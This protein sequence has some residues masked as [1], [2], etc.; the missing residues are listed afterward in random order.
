MIREFRLKNAIGNEWDLNDR[1]SFLQ[2]P[3]GLG[4]EYDVEYQQIGNI[5]IK[6]TDNMKQKEASGQIVFKTYNRYHYFCLFIQHKPIVLQYTTQAGT[7][8]MDVSIDRLDKS[9]LDTG[10]LYCDVRI[11]GLSTFYKVIRA[12]NDGS[13]VA[14]KIYPYSYNY[15]YSDYSQGAVQFESD[16]VLDSGVKITI[17]G[18]CTNPSW[19]H[20]INGKI[21]SSGKVNCKIKDGNRLVVDNTKIPYE[22]AEYDSTGT[23]VQNLYQESDFSTERFINL[24]FGSNKIAFS[25]E[26]ENS[27]A[28]IAEGKLIY[29]S[30]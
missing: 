30:V 19:T 27:I 28:L 5:F 12:E 4:F 18:P 3:D 23:Y 25:H 9:E 10:G 13:I 20:Y 16:S 15:R 26:G 1:S 21:S 22:I 8:N 17:L 7:F 2:D 29:E 6:L 14:G 11:I 24:G